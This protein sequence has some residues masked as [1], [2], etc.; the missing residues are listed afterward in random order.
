MDEFLYRS[1][2]TIVVEFCDTSP[3]QQHARVLQNQTKDT[4]QH[5][6]VS[7]SSMLYCVY[8]ICLGQNISAASFLLAVLCTRHTDY[9]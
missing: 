7:N 8:C 3:E 1:M 5:A 9:A 6:A 2:L 4:N